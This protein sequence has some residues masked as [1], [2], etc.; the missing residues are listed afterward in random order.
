VKRFI[1]PDFKNEYY[2]EGLRQALA[3]P[4]V[5]LEDFNMDP[6]V[7]VDQ[8]SKWNSVSVAHMREVMHGLL[9]ETV[10]PEITFDV[11]KKAARIALAYASW[12]AMR[13][14]SDVEMRYQVSF[15]ISEAGRTLSGEILEA[16]EGD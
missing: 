8:F 6:R 14:K 16:S 4:K 11:R 3:H 7:C 2:R 9:F 10:I 1:H 5:I 15:S 13:G 12:W